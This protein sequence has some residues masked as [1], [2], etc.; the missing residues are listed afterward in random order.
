MRYVVT[1]LLLA[2]TAMAAADSIGASIGG[3]TTPQGKPIQCLLPANL[4]QRNTGGSDGAGLCVYASARH[5][6]RLQNDPAFE[7]LFDWMRQRPGGSYP[8]K[9]KRTLEQF[10]KDKGYPVPPYVQIESND[11][12]I[13][14][15]ACKTGRMPGVTYAYG[16]RYRGKIAHMVSLVHADDQCF[17]ILDNNFPGENAYEHLSPQE[18]LR[19]YSGGRTGWSIV[20]LTPPPPPVLREAP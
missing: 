7:G 17:T 12:D 8:E 13:L 14:R 16:S 3:P 10:C 4:H 18:F 19:T 1:V 11:L 20:L 9:F 5:S 15:L 6:G 2:T